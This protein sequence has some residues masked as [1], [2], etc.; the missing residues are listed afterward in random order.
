[1][2]ARMLEVFA[3]PANEATRRCE[4]CFRRVGKRKQKYCDLHSINIANA[5]PNEVSQR[6]RLRQSQTLA[7]GYVEKSDQLFG[8]LSNTPFFLDPT[9]FLSRELASVRASCGDVRKDPECSIKE[10]EV[11]LRL[12]RSVV[13]TSLFAEFEVLAKSLSIAAVK[14]KKSHTD[15]LDNLKASRVRLDEVQ[16]KL[17]RE[18]QE[19]TLEKTSRRGLLTELAEEE[20]HISDDTKLLMDAVNE[21]KKIACLTRIESEKC[22][23]NLTVKA[24]LVKFFNHIPAGALLPTDANHPLIKKT[25]DKLFTLP[26]AP[27]FNLNQIVREDLLALRAW[28]EVGGESI[29][30]ALSQ[31]GKPLPVSRQVRKLPWDFLLECIDKLGKAKP[32]PQEIADAIYERSNGHIR[33]TRSAVSQAITRR[34]TTLDAINPH[35]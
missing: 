18:L 12:L 27:A 31:S 15:V 21:L 4:L 35:A 23:K 5:D 33:V 30:K 19:K 28:I 29:D 7:D 1:M 14:A 9:G 34:K 17:R 13:G 22:N 25:D 32:S 11:F 3:T 2:Q 24:F 8:E 16:D 26:A 20:T 6:T 10:L